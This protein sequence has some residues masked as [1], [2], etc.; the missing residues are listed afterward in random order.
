MMPCDE[1]YDNTS[2]SSVH[3]YADDILALSGNRHNVSYCS[4][5]GVVDDATKPES[6]V[7]YT[8][9]SCSPIENQGVCEQRVNDHIPAFV[10]ICNASLPYELPAQKEFQPYLSINTP[11]QSPGIQFL[12]ADEGLHLKECGTASTAPNSSEPMSTSSQEVADFFVLKECSVASCQT[13]SARTAFCEVSRCSTSPSSSTA[14]EVEGLL[15]DSRLSRGVEENSLYSVE[16]SS[17]SEDSSSTSTILSAESHSTLLESDDSSESSLFSDDSFSRYERTASSNRSS[18]SMK[19]RKSFERRDREL[20]RLSLGNKGYRIYLSRQEELVQQHAY[21]H[22]YPDPKIL[23][24]NDLSADHHVEEACAIT[25]RKHSI[26]YNV[27]RRFLFERYHTAPGIATLLI[28]IIAHVSCYDAL[29]Q[30]F[31]NSFFNFGYYRLAY[32]LSFMVGISLLRLTG[33]IWNWG[34]ASLYEAVKFDLHN[35]LRLGDYDIKFIR[36]IN[37][38]KRL[39]QFLSIIGIYLCF[40]S[41]EF[42]LSELLL[43]TVCRVNNKVIEE[44]PSQVHGIETWLNRVLENNSFHPTNNTYHLSN[45]FV[46]HLDFLESEED[47]KCYLSTDIIEEADSTYLYSKLSYSS[48]FSLYGWGEE[49]KLISSNCQVLLSLTNA[50][51]SVALLYIMGIGFWD[52]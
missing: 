35:K 7:S 51:I 5:I 11:I 28:Y 6:L 41:V 12:D 4:A 10:E 2:L 30:I 14:T 31:M 26:T 40:I 46:S 45:S 8:E 33:S 15:E 50:L 42:A 16:S 1:I 20:R 37:K 36:W 22:L 17:S 34:T 44:L 24:R 48:F 13:S 43:P 39:Q 32:L 52:D 23:N 19:L 47:D 38:R 21:N 49:S 25:E 29:H 3:L 27:Q 9:T 18:R